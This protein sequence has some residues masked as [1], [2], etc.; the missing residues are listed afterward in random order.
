MWSLSHH[1]SYSAVA[2]LRL[3]FIVGMACQAATV[4]NSWL[5]VLGVEKKA[6]QTGRTT[7]EQ[8]FQGKNNLDIFSYSRR[9][10]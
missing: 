10:K 1:E 2:D 5:V 3:L 8:L 4:I 9:K 7:I 6:Q